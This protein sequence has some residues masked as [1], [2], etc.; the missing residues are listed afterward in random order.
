MVQE[1]RHA[2][3]QLRMTRR[4]M[5]GRGLTTLA[6]GASLVL[7]AACQQQAAPAKPAGEQKPAQPAT[8]A[9]PVQAAP[10][11]KTDS[12]PAE[13]A[14][15]AAEQKPATAAKPD[16]GSPAMAAAG[17][18]PKRGGTLR[19]VVQNDF[20]TMWPLITTGPTAT[21]CYDA[22]VNWRLGA[23]GRWG[24]QPG[25]AESWELSDKAA[26]FKLRR[27]IK[28]HD[29][30]DLNADAVKYNVDLWMKHPKSIA[31]SFLRT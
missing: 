22:L 12:K 7:L 19:A 30:S 16:G 2:M 27:G 20:V 23:D 6:G 14:K 4:Q 5:L 10:A 3:T 17:E 15:P 29:G 28:F 25:L 24:P 26:V 9:T 31:K 8:A 18:M 21:M 1:W 11:A 13:A